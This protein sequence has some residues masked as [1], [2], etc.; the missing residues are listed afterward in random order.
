MGQHKLDS[1]FRNKLNQREIKP[2][3]NAWDRLDAMLTVAEEKK[4]KRSYG[5]LYIA[6]SFIGFLLIATV[7]FSH[8][9]E[10]ID[11]RRNPVVIEDNTQK[12][13]EKETAITKDTLPQSQQPTAIASVSNQPHKEIKVKS[14]NPINNQTVEIINPIQKNPELIA[15]SSINQKTEQQTTTVKVDE[16]LALVVPTPTGNAKPSVKV[17]AKNLLSQVDGEVNL[18]FREKMLRTARR[19]YQEVAEAVSTRNTQQ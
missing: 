16:L 7:F 6:A 15:N 13:N 4:P 8:T 2:S 1:D 12:P 3:E 18:S 10:M 14:K 19:N 11:I 5:W 17:N 9:E